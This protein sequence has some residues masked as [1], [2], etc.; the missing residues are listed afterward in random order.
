[1]RITMLGVGSAF[2]RLRRNSSLMAESGATRLVVDCGRT[3]PVALEEAGFGLADV[4][5]FL[6][7]HLHA[8]H[9]GG[10]E[11]VA[12]SARFFERARVRLYGT[13]SMLDRLWSCSLK[14]GLEFVEAELGTAVPQTLEDFFEPVVVP[15]GAFFEISPD[16]RVRLH[17]TYHVRGMESYAVEVEAPPGGRDHRVFF[18]GDTRFDPAL[19]VRATTEACRV[20]HDCQLVDFGEGNRLGVHCSYRQ[21]LGLPPEIRAQLWLYHYGDTELPDAVADGFAGFLEAG[22]PFDVG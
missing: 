16:L 21:L 9:I 22:H 18:T 4:T 12:L 2:S 5:G 20:L 14:G 10:L 6:I 15:M 7:T 8:D 17:P 11:E 1:M 3:V 19:I 13:A